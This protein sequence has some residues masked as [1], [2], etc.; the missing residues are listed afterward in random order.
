MTNQLQDISQ[1][2]PVFSAGA[3]QSSLSACK[4]AS[5]PLLQALNSLLSGGLCGAASVFFLDE[6]RAA[7]SLVAY[8]SERGIEARRLSLPL[9]QSLFSFFSQSTSSAFA[10]KG[11]DAAALKKAL[12]PDSDLSGGAFVAVP[13]HLSGNR[14]ALLAALC[15]PT[16]ARAASEGCSEDDCVP[17]S[18]VSEISFLVE[19]ASDAYSSIADLQALASLDEAS[20]A[21][22]ESQLMK[23]KLAVVKAVADSPSPVLIIGEGGTGKKFYARKLHSLSRRADKPFLSINCSAF[24]D[25]LLEKMLFGAGEEGSSMEGGGDDRQGLFEKASGGTVLLRGIESLSD[26]MQEKL[27]SVLQAGSIEKNEGSTP[28][29]VRVAVSTSRDL[30]KLVAA[31]KFSS[32]LYYALSVIPLYLPPLAARSEDIIPLSYLFLRQCSAET[33]KP[34]LFFS[35]GAKEALLTHRWHGNVREL[36]NA[37]ARACVSADPPCV[38]EDDLLLNNPLIPDNNINKDKALKPAMLRLKKQYVARILAEN[39]WNQT[40]T[41]KVLG[42]QRTY[43][44]RLVKE[45][46]IREQ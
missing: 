15:T 41:A 21:V 17:E 10:I 18:L 44:S 38:T 14:A 4:D 23:E 13:M 12:F 31:K 7:V 28:I 20:A 24:S 11:D 46:K 6:N 29:R 42:I 8:P 2:A 36:K 37:I 26:A 27:M 9:P 35:A 25:A 33:A 43:L 19:S 30:E 16:E 39:G 40:R 34:L 45:L 3:C 1:E 5:L 22:T 32:R